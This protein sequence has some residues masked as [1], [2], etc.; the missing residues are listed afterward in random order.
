[1]KAITVA[2]ILRDGDYHLGLRLVAG[3]IGLSREVAVP[4]IQKPGLALAG[5]LEQIHP[6]RVQI[7]GSVE[8]SYLSTISEKQREV[9]IK[10]LCSLDVACFII[11]RG[12][13]VPR[14]LIREANKR[15][16][17]VLKTDL[18][19]SVLINR[20]TTF[21]EE[22]LAETVA[23]HGVLADVLEVGIL[24]IGKSGIGK[25]ECALDLVLKGHRLVADDM[26][27]IRKKLPAHLIGR[28]TEL[29][30]YHMEIRGLG[31][32]NVRDLFGI[33]S[34]RDEKEIDVVVELM[35]WAGEEHDRLGLDEKKYIILGV[36][37]P[38]LR[39][40]VR[41]GRNMATIIEVAARNHLLKMT[42]RHSS[43]ELQEAL[44]KKIQ[45]KG[46]AKG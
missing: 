38:Y 35:E 4:R 6:D 40:P 25:S 41:P 42:G 27:E 33:T 23:V 2:D 8:L 26:V 39:V 43:K 14:I 34:I 16:I 44:M 24:I 28:G 7:L 29:I 10:N 5:Y 37:L 30:K 46:K 1:M 45:G 32:I 15:G 18:L 3:K 19:S 12:L 17:A 36:A 21:L 9:A 11:T 13:P 31:I 20:I 22:K